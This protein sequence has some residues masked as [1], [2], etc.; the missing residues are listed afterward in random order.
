MKVDVV[1][2]SAH[3]SASPAPAVPGDNNGCTGCRPAH[4]RFEPV[5]LPHIVDTEDEWRSM[6]R[7]ARGRFFFSRFVLYLNIAF[8]HLAGNLKIY[9]SIFFSPITENEGFRERML[10][11]LDLSSG[12]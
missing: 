11:S 6:N 8:L 9:Y 12:S 4:L 10:G 3:K 1:D 2:V 5:S 7:L